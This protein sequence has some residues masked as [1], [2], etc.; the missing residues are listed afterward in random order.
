[1]NI[2]VT[3]ANGFVGRALCDYLKQSRKKII[4]AVRHTTKADETEMEPIGPDSNHEI[5]LKECDVLV[6]LAARVHVMRETASSSLDA[7]RKVN[8]FG[9]LNLA[10]QAAQYGVR[11]FIFLSSVKVNGESGSFS[12]ESRAAPE[13]AYAISKWEAEEGLKRISHETGMEVVI[14]R[15]PLV[16]GPGVAAN[17]FKLMQLVDRGIPLPFGA[18]HNR[19]SLIYIDNLVD[20]IARCVDHPLVAG[21]TYLVSDGEDVS[22]TLLI[23][24]L[25]NAL[26]SPLRLFPIP[27]GMLRLGGKILGKTQQMDRVLEWLVVDS[28]NIRKD[29]G[30]TPPFT[31]DEGLSRTA[32]WY[33]V[34]YSDR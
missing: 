12:E 32:E 27:S 29:L 25:A 8:T 15:P 30:W 2:L 3:G 33:R 17:F 21:K 6:H 10:R 1:M 31:M 22:T 7:F 13:D 9:T 14:L 4:Q 5:I 24:K 11:R 23:K 19:R 20:I 26:G 16:Y 34:L 28:N 18:I